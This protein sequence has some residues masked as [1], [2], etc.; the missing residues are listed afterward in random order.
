MCVSFIAL[1]YTK[2]RKVFFE[3]LEAPPQKYS[4]NDYL[5]IHAIIQKC[6]RAHVPIPAWT[7][8]EHVLL[9]ASR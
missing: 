5:N 7:L 9:I 2:L 3:T 8:A 1:T 4:W 6:T